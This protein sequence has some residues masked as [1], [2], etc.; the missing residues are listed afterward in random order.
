ARRLVRVSSPGVV[1]GE[2]WVPCGTVLVTGGTGAL[3]ARVARW[4]VAR[5]A[6]HVVLTSRRGVQAPGAAELEAELVSAGARVTIAACDVADREALARLLE[7]LR[8]ELTAVFHAAGVLDDGV[9]DALIPER[10]ERVWQAKADSAR[11][12]HEFTRDLD[13]SAFVLFSSISG[14]LGSSGQANYAAANAYLDALAEERRGEGLPAV[15]VAWG[16]WADG[17]MAAEGVLERRLRREG[18]P[19]MDPQ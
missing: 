15:S 13:L 16:P 3:G 7:P 9:L 11:H 18:M 19:P 5:G 14:T 1:P 12:L 2:G 17:G 8:S 6:E 4:L 10:F